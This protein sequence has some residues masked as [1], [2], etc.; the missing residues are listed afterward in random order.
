MVRRASASVV[1]LKGTSNGR[2]LE[3]MVKFLALYICESA[4]GDDD[5]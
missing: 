3:N 2:D 1:E 5:E 4:E